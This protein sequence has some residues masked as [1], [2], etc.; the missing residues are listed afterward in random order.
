MRYFA[1]DENGSPFPI[2]YGKDK[3]KTFYSDK[4]EHIAS[5]IAYYTHRWTPVLMV[6]FN[7][8]HRGATPSEQK[9]FERELNSEFF[10][11]ENK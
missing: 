11:H 1:V 10:F 3:G 6:D 4:I 9:K 2:C 5:Y 7:G 8:K